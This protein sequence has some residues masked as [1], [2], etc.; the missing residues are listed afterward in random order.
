M[1]S[2]VLKDDGVRC[3]MTLQKIWGQR[4]EG[5]DLKGDGLGVKLTRGGFVIVSIDCQVD[6]I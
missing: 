6:R 1:E 2:Y 5:Y 4:V 3:Q